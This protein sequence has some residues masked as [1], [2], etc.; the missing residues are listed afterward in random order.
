MQNLIDNAVK[1]TKAGEIKVRVTGSPGKVHIIVSDTGIGIS[2]DFMGRLFDVFSQ[3]VSGYSRPYEGNGLGLA[4]SK[5]LA[6]I[7]NGDITVVSQKG[8]GSEFTVTF[9]SI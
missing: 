5:K 8:N 7:N 9:N 2:E 6:Q 1:Y 4:L 3:E